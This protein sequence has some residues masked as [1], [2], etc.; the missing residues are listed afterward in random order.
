MASGAKEAKRRQEARETLGSFAKRQEARGKGPR[1]VFERGIKG[2]IS[3]LP[4]PLERGKA[5]NGVPKKMQ[6]Y[7]RGGAL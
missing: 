7:G 1:G 2:A 4:L 6:S 3:G 5:P